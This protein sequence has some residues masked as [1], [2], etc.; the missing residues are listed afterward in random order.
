MS[1][2]VVVKEQKFNIDRSTSMLLRSIKEPV[3]DLTGKVTPNFMM[4]LQIYQSVCPV[5]IN[6]KASIF[7]I[8]DLFIGKFGEV[9]LQHLGLPNYMS[10]T[11]IVREEYEKQQAR[12]LG[13]LQ[14]YAKCADYIHID[15]LIEVIGQTVATLIRNYPPGFIEKIKPAAEEYARICWEM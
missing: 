13:I 10:D 7:Y 3:V 6:D 12:A 11:F 9:I 1:L 4:F 2:T 15:N 8:G 14:V 5:K